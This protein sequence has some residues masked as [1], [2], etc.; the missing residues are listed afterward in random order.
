MGSANFVV[1]REPRGFMRVLQCI[2]AIVSMRAMI[3]FEGYVDVQY[4]ADKGSSNAK[5]AHLTYNYPFDLSSVSM[6]VPQCDPTGNAGNSHIYLMGDFSND[7]EFFFITCV[8]SIL[9][10]IAVTFVY[11]KLSDLYEKNGKVALADFVCSVVL[12]VFWL[13]GSAAWAYGLSNLKS[14]TEPNTLKH[15]LK[16]CLQGNP[17]YISCGTITAGG[18]FGLN[19]S[20]ITGFLNFFLWASD[21]WFLYKETPWFHTRQGVGYPA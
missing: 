1:F 8:L 17:E 15:S 4:C 7:A 6:T 19:L 9:Y 16:C 21:L 13:S 2:F 3:G 14:L 11:V 5:L 12:A 18:Y 10:T 20:V